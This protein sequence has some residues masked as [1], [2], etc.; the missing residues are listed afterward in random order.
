MLDAL[1]KTRHE[2]HIHNL[3]S[4]HLCHWVPVRRTRKTGSPGRDR[5]PSCSLL[6]LGGG[7]S[8]RSRLV[9]GF[10]LTPVAPA[11]YQGI[12]RGLAS[13]CCASFAGP[14]GSG[15]GRELKSS[16]SWRC[17]GLRPA[18]KWAGCLVAVSRGGPSG[19]CAGVAFAGARLWGRR[20]QSC[21][22]TTLYIGLRFPPLLAAPRAPGRSSG[23]LGGSAGCELGYP[24][25][26]F[27]TRICSA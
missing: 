16:C 21:P 5:R 6:S 22:A 15:S 20:A 25:G 24:C 10:Q 23:S 8:R 9:A 7:G 14:S 17:H 11:A 13:T 19:P 26:P 18:A 1:R 3:Q 4:W 27:G 2:P 12:S